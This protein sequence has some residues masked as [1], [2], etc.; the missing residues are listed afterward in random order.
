VNK[1]RT[2]HAALLQLKSF[3]IAVSGAPALSSPGMSLR[4][5]GLVCLFLMLRMSA[6][7]KLNAAM[8]KRR[9]GW[10]RVGSE[11]RCILLLALV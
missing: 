4:L 6:G 11:L 3:Q 2:S 10:L 1:R 8:I 5:D 9:R 7:A